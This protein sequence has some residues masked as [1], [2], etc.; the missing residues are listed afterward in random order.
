MLK[1][2]KFLKGFFTNS[3]GILFSRILGFIRDLITANVLGA[4]VYSDIFF[5]AFKLPNLFRRL[6]G[7]GAFTQAF[8]PG[9]VAA[10]KKSLFSASVLLRFLV[11]IV[12]LTLIVNIFA[13]FFTKLIAF[14]FDKN[15]IDMA[16]PYVKINFWYLVFIF[17]VTLFAS[18]LQYKSHFATTAFSTALLNISMIISLIL[19]KDKSKEISVLYLSYGVVVGGILQAFVHILALKYTG[20]LRVIVGGFKGL[21][22]GKK[23]DTKGF[24][25]NFFHG[26]VGSSTAQVGAFIDTWFA[27]FLAFGSISYLYYANRIFQLPLA[28]F[29][30]AL[31]T[32]LFPKISKQ[33]K[34]GNDKLALDLL[35]KSFHFLFGLLLFST[36]GGVMLS[37]EI[38]Y[39]LFQ[40]GEFTSLDTLNSAK[41]LN[42]YMIGLLPFGLAKIFS[43][44]LYAK[45]KQNIAAKITIQT[46]IINLISCAILIKPFGVSGLALASS[47]GGS[48]LFYRNIKEFGFGNFLA[49]INLKKITLIIAICLI[50][51]LIL[52]LFKEILYAYI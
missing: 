10:K 45:M 43:L 8:L 21:K 7:E 47:I 44:W 48:Y 52:W 42:M 4:G 29:A 38:I 24:Y 11:F 41:V 50:E 23:A 5:I 6:F 35:S 49:I 14:G 26:V 13:P 25:K 28:L 12:F 33:I 2:F 32:A 17:L 34:A 31:S 39:I 37:K 16:V 46:L 18:L 3:F 30:I 36:I 15:T 40:R 19:A 27:S 1:K 20:M 9:F 22:N 51:I